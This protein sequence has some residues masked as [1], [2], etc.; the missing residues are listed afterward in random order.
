[1]NPSERTCLLIEASEKMPIKIVEGSRNMKIKWM[2]MDNI[3]FKTNHVP[4]GQNVNTQDTIKIF[5]ICCTMY[6]AFP[7]NVVEMSLMEQ[8][9]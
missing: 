1:M 9:D 2:G 6:I 3:V 4:C 5:M 8:A 7:V